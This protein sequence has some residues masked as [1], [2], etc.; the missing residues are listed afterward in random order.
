MPDLQMAKLSSR[1]FHEDRAAPRQMA[2]LDLAPVGEEAW[3]EVIQKMDEVYKDL[4]ESQMLLERQ[5]AALQEAQQF[6]GSVLGSM[7]DVLIACDARGGIQQVNPAM[8]QLSGIAESDLVGTAILDLFEDEGGTIA[9]RLGE[10]LRSAQ[11]ITDLEVH[12]RQNGSGTTP[13]ALNCSLRLD[14]RGKRVGIVIVGRPVGELRRAYSELDLAHQKLTRTQQQLVISEKMAALGRVVAGVAHELNNPISFVFGNMHA[15]KRYGVAITAYLNAQHCDADPQS[16]D[17]LRQRLK[18]DSIAAD[19]EPLIEGTL[20]GAE[21][22]RAIIQD[23]RRFSS[24]QREMPETFDVT[25]VVRTAVDWVVRAE[26]VKPMVAFDMPEQLDIT[27]RKGYL[28]QVIVN[29][30]HNAADVLQGVAEPRIEISCRLEGDDV[31]IKVRD[32]GTGVAEEHMD[33]IFEPF[34]TTKP[35]GQGTGLGLY[36]SYG[37]IKEQNGDLTV[38]NHP[39]GG[40]VFTLRFPAD[41]NEK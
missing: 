38:A 19:I 8:V 14:H 29:L 7:T 17:A 10:C 28:H 18:I 32:N 35:I 24:H 22:V 37:L 1:H 12:M 39:D 15:L 5:H 26:R 13:L 41:V 11:S 23:L 30:V 2:G 27:A 36:V 40:A 33:Q 34:F 21:R 3:I 4:I 16:L 31:V 9:A 25:R 6:I 20:E